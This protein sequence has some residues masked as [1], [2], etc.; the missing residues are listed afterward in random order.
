MKI[1]ILDEI[2]STNEYLKREYQK[3]PV[4]T[5]VLAKKQIAGKGRRGHFWQSQENQ[6]MTVSFLDK[7][8]QNI[9]DA[10]KYTIIAAK[11]VMELLKKNNIYSTVKWPN[12]IYVNDQKICGILVETILDLDL[13][14]IVVGIGLNVNY[15]KP[16]ICMKDVT[17]IQYEISELLLQLILYFNQNI[18]L[19]Y[20]NQFSQILKYVNQ[21]SYLKDKWIDYKGHGLVC[22]RK[23][24]EQGEVEF[25]DKLGNVY[26]E[27]M[28]VITLSDDKK[29]IQS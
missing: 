24:N 8:I 12:D 25:I 27:I 10:W 23:L 26:Q 5:C 20:Q 28:N 11:S 22:F 4:H 15:A 18:E 16:Y 2:D 9:E 13:K 19:L 1:I 29:F 17:K 3:L 7:D 21:M 14:G 6:N